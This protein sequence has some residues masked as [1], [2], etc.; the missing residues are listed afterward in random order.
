M[1]QGRI[2]E[3]SEMIALAA[4]RISVDVGLPMAESIML[5]SANACEATL[6]TQDEDFKG[7]PGVRYVPTKSR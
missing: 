3:L 4:A 5:A 1:R 2:V 6:W 7:M